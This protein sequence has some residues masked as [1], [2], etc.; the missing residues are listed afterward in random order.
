MLEALK[1]FIDLAARAIPSMTSWRAKRKI[2]NIAVEL[3]MLYTRLNEALMRGEAIV[4][5]LTALVRLYELTQRG[6]RPLDDSLAPLGDRIEELLAA[7][8][9]DLY[10]IEALFERWKTEFQVLDGDAFYDLLLKVRDKRSAIG[11]LVAVCL[12]GHLTTVSMAP[13]LEIEDLGSIRREILGS[14]IALDKVWLPE[15]DEADRNATFTALSAYLDSRQPRAQLDEIRRGLRGFRE[16]LA[17][18]FDLRE[19][20]PLVGTTRLEKS[21]SRSP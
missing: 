19:I 2:N 3:F 14:A 6:R 17:N 11:M 9:D 1:L 13:L 8:A 16:V 15:T 5:Q 21:E 7:Q 12:D 10:E 20:L 4:N 18:T